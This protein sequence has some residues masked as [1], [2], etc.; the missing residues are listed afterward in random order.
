MAIKIAGTPFADELF[1]LLL[2]LYENTKMPMNF[3]MFILISVAFTM[4]NKSG[5][6][7]GMH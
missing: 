7:S 2:R 5:K 3:M 4:H 1:L 6:E